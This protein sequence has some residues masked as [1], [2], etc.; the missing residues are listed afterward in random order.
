MSD[1]KLILTILIIGLGT[2][3]FRFSF[4][5]LYDKF[6]L[7]KW[8]HQSLRYVPAAVLSALIFP[9]II[10]NDGQIWAS[11]SNPKLMASIA[12]VIVAWKTKK[13][14]LTIA[15]GLIIYWLIIFT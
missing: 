4:I 10:I 8:V 7:P 2:F 15:V 13:L 12:A 9:A 14:F 3:L 5:Y 11:Y 6:K 1:F